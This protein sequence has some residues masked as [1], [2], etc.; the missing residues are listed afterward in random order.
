MTRNE[1]SRCALDWYDAQQAEGG[2][3][4]DAFHLFVLGLIPTDGLTVTATQALELGNFLELKRR[5]E[6]EETQRSSHA[7]GSD[8]KDAAS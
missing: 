8:E 7:N 3:T 6:R 1:L 4:R 5:I 2:I